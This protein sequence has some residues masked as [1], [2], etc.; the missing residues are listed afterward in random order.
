MRR[1]R[2]KNNLGAITG[3]AQ[4]D[5]TWFGV[6]VADV[7]EPIAQTVTGFHQVLHASRNSRPMIMKLEAVPGDDG[8]SNPQ[9]SRRGRWKQGRADGATTAKPRASLRTVVS[10]HVALVARG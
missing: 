1:F 6:S 10:F 7:P 2:A 9:A 5:R 4:S 8:D 3:R